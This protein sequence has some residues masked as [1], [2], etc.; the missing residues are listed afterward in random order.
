MKGTLWKTIVFVVVF[1]V[2]FENVNRLF[3]DKY[4]YI[5]YKDF[6]SERENLDVLFLGTSRVINGVDPMEL[7]HDW[8]IASYNLA[9]YS[10]TICTNYWQLVNAL[11]Y[12][13][14]KVVVLDLFAS[15]TEYTVNDA[16]LHHFTDAMPMG[17]TKIRTVMDLEEENRW[18]QYLFEFS[19][20]H[21]RWNGELTLQD[22]KPELWKTRGGE[23]RYNV[24]PNDQ[25][26]F[27]PKEQY[28]EMSGV[29]LEYLQK[30]I[31]LCKQKE[32][33]IILTYM[34]YAPDE[35]SQRNA[36]YGYI[37]AK[38]NDIPYL[39]IIREGLEFNFATDM[40]DDGGHMSALGARKVTDFLG[41]Y[42]TEKCNVPDRR[43]DHSYDYW[44][45]DYTDY[46]NYMQFKANMINDQT[47]LMFF[48]VLLSDRNLE[49]AIYLGTD[50][51]ALKDRNI[52]ELLESIAIF[53]HAEYFI[54]N[55]FEDNEICIEVMNKNT[56]EKISVKTFYREELNLWKE[57]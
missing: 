40:A 8:G 39:D 12:T 52:A 15:H 25:P 17:R 44:N 48:L 55:S 57:G 33:Q 56:N 37:I 51:L 19:L 38:K 3:M 6:Y 29:N 7:W 22:I 30:I 10:E 13:Q 9:N 49:T 4:S 34:P 42:L 27:V 54:K 45:A 26:Q 36:N 31:D 1:L 35:T 14:P 28:N 46:T 23:I 2:I 50:S 21:S 16:M 47:D 24:V 43:N 32:I 18:D 41:K 20:Y 11:Q 53:G 5:K